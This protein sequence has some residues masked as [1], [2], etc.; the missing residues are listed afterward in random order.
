MY[1][2]HSFVAPSNRCVTRMEIRVIF[3]VTQQ[4][5]EKLSRYKELLKGN[6]FLN[7]LSVFVRMCVRVSVCLCLA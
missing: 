5:D 1:S 2:T 6:G 7:F 3:R 4:I